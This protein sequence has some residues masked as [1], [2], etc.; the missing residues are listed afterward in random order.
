MNPKLHKYK[1]E[2]D[3]AAQKEQYWGQ[4]RKD[5]EM[6]VMEMENMEIQTFLASQNLTMDGLK[7]LVAQLQAK[8]ETQISEPTPSEEPTQY[9]QQ[10]KWEDAYDDALY[11]TCG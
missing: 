8:K 11:Y 1:E 3:K 4:R 9:T 7:D 10:Q 2:R 6:K 5:A